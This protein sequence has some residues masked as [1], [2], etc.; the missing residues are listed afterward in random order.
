LDTRAHCGFRRRR[1][2]PEQRRQS[3]TYSAYITAPTADNYAYARA[4]LAPPQT[5]LTVSGDFDITVEGQGGQEVPIFKLYDASGNRLVYVYRR[6]SSATIYA[7]Y[8]GTTNY[9]GTK[10]APGTWG[11]SSCIRSQRALPAR[12]ARLR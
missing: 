7:V 2:R 5:D 12:E 3:G 11:A 10:F 8:N 6:N 1:D 9:T 4:T